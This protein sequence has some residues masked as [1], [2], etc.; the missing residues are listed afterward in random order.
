MHMDHKKV[1]KVTHPEGKGEYNLHSGL[2]CTWN[3]K[4]IKILADQFE[5]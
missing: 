4:H 5:T 1:S 2:S 3:S